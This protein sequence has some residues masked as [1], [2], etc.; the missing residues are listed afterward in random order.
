MK[1]KLLF[2]IFSLAIFLFLEPPVLKAQQIDTTGFIQGF[3]KETVVLISNNFLNSEISSYEENNDHT[4]TPK[5][6]K[7][8][9]IITVTEELLN[10]FS[11]VKS[12]VLELSLDDESLQEAYKNGLPNIRLT[13]TQN[14]RIGIGVG[15]NIKALLNLDGLTESN[16]QPQ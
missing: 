16:N 11:Q 15:A 4:W 6:I 5:P 10:T 14:L 13:D 8:T 2:I 9:Q 1:K 7:T 3:D 12:I